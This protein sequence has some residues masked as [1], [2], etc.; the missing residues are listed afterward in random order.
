[1]HG[2]VKVFAVPLAYHL[3]ARRD[4]RIQEQDLWKVKAE[5]SEIIKRTRRMREG[6]GDKQSRVC[7]A[8]PL[9]RIAGNT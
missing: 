5:M 8:M 3:F 6:K 1:M 2:D 4:L 9:V 7:F